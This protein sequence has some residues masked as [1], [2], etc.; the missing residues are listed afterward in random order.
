VREQRLRV[1]SEVGVLLLQHL[2]EFLALRDPLAFDPLMQSRI[3]RCTLGGTARRLRDAF[4]KSCAGIARRAIARQQLRIPPEP[5]VGSARQSGRSTDAKCS[6]CWQQRRRHHPKRWE[7]DAE[8][9]TPPSFADAL[10]ARS[11]RTVIEAVAADAQQTR[12]EERAWQQHFS[13]A[14][15]AACCVRADSFA[16]AVP[17]DA[18]QRHFRLVTRHA[19]GSCDMRIV[20]QR[21]VERQRRPFWFA[22]DLIDEWRC[23]MQQRSAANHE[24]RLTCPRLCTVADRLRELQ[25]RR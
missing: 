24:C 20:L 5:P 2:I 7:I 25:R 19:Q 3:V 18:P 11:A 16:R 23:G 8:E 6:G 17:R 1:C 22:Q 4:H 13:A 14:H 12:C 10:V 21:F 9:S 15:C